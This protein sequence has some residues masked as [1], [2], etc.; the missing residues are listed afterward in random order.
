MVSPHDHDFLE[1]VLVERGRAEHITSSR[2]VLTSA[3]DV[4][5]IKPGRW[6]TYMGVRG[7][8]VY[9][10]LIGPD[11]VQSLAPLVR[12]EPGAV[13]LLWR[14]PAVQ[15]G[16]GCL[17]LRLPAGPR[18]HAQRLLEEMIR[19]RFESRAGGDLSALGHLMLYLGLLSG[20]ALACR[21]RL[22]EGKGAGRSSPTGGVSTEPAPAVVDAIQILEDRFAE[23]HTAT[24][25][26]SAVGLS[27]SH[28]RREFR[29][30]TGQSP[31]RYLAGVRVQRACR[32]LVDTTRSIT[33][34]AGAVGWPDP[35]LFARRFREHLGLSP[36]SYRQ[37]NMRGS[38]R[39]RVNGCR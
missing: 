14:G 24:G 7:L 37:S 11:L 9:N 2:R 3:G 13:E 12:C 29:R 4:W 33:E 38:S 10:C 35:N 1:I 23:P 8:C 15:A 32:L 28:L 19:C 36:R 18:L 22:A 16:D 20:V 30:M 39:S 6:H 31:M 27:A 21:E 26:A 5:V 25:L 34:I 17:Q